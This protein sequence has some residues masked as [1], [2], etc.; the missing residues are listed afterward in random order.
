M[1]SLEVGKLKARQYKSSVILSGFKLCLF[2]EVLCAN[3]LFPEGLHVLAVT[4]GL[5]LFY[6]Q[7]KGTLNCFH[8]YKVKGN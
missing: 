4:V 7:E 3:I 6:T 2:V 5:C 8:T 1:I